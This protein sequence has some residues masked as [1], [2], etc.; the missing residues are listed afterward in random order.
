MV[1]KTK[2]GSKYTAEHV[3]ITVPLSILKKG[4]IEFIPFLPSKKMSAINRMG[5]G[6]IEKVVIEFD[7]VFWDFEADFINYVSDTSGE[8]VRVINLM[9]YTKK[10]WLV[11]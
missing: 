6:L 3:I 11:M 10:P 4:M 9:K 5:V 2:S 1:I 8:W 7:K